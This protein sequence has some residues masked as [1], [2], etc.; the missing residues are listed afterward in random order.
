VLAL[1]L[2]TL[3]LEDS[4][5][6]TLTFLNNQSGILTLTS[7]L[8]AISVFFYQQDN[9]KKKFNE[10]IVNASKGLITDLNQLGESY[11]SGIFPK[12]T[13]TEKKID[14]STTSMGLEYYQSVVN[15]GLITYYDETTQ[16]E[17]SNL[18]YNMLLFDEWS[19]EF[20]HV[21]FYSALPKPDRDSILTK[22]AQKLTNHENEI[23]TKIPIVKSLLDAE[24]KK[25]KKSWKDRFHTK[26]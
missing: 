18:Y 15:S 24:I 17:L 10:R 21:G 25:Y 5:T 22:I 1:A 20:N 11:S 19:K 14:F 23:K 13:W 4:I 8:I 16:I 12:A 26:C 9:E 7:I 6:S 3:N 2:S